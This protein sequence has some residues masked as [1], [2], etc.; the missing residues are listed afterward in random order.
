MNAARGEGRKLRK[1]KPLFRKTGRSVKM[2]PYVTDDLYKRI[3]IYCAKKSMSISAFAEAA[4][5]E[6]LSERDDAEAVLKKLDRYYLRMDKID[7]NLNIL[8]EAFT[9]FLQFWFAHTPP[10]PDIDKKDA[11][12]KAKERYAAFIEYLRNNMLDG[13]RFADQFVEPVA[14]ENELRFVTENHER[15]RS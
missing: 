13:R 9:L 5:E 4:F 8:G 15:L 7:S 12:F 3:R 11:N 2:N 1:N 6:Y 14:N 10:I